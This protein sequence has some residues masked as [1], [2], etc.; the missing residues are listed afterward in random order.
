MQ[1]PDFAPHAP[2]PDPPRP[3][4]PR[5]GAPAPERATALPAPARAGPR[6]LTR[7]GVTWTVTEQD[8][9]GV[10]GNADGARGPR[11]LV[12]ASPEAV[13]RVWDYPPDW[14]ALPDDACYALSWRT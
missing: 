2:Q 12:F 9:A 11:C 10:P 6:T 1:S 4:A 7:A 13:R 8:G 14:R 3:G 5:R